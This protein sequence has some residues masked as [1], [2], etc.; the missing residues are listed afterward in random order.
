MRLVIVDLPRLPTLRALNRGGIG[1]NVS[2]HP[3]MGV[4]AGLRRPVVEVI[5]ALSYSYSLVDCNPQIHVFENRRKSLCDS[6]LGPL[7]AARR[8]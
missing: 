5:H 6:G 7:G 3:T 4:L 1:G 8:P 2:S